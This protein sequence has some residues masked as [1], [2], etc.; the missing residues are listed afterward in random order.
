MS[1]KKKEGIEIIQRGR[2]DYYVPLKFET[3]CN[4]KELCG[5][6]NNSLNMNINKHLSELQSDMQDAY[7]MIQDN[8]YQNREGKILFKRAIKKWFR[9]QRDAQ[10]TSLTTS[11][12]DTTVDISPTESGIR[13][14]MHPGEMRAYTDRCEEL[15]RERTNYLRIYG[16]DLVNSQFRYTLLPLNIQLINGERVWLHAI[17]YVFENLMGI[18]KLE[19]PL[20]N[21]SSEPLKD[22][23][24]DAYIKS[25]D[26]HWNLIPKNCEL[27]IVN[28]W[29]AYIRKIEKE[30]KLKI[31]GQVGV[32]RN[33]ILAR[34]DNMPKQIHSI[35]GDVQED[36]YKIIAAP[37]PKLGCTSYRQVARD[38]IEKQSWNC[39][40]MRWL[41]S[42]TG[43]CLSFTDTAFLEWKAI[44]YL[45]N[46]EVDV[47]SN[48]D[49]DAIDKG[50]IQDLCFNTELALV[51]PILKFM[52]SSYTYSMK[53]YK[54]KEMH[55]VQ[56]KFNQNIMFI[57]RLQ[58]S[59][60][61]SVSEQI[62]V[63]ERLMP[64]YL[65]TKITSEKMH[66]L[67]CIIS[68]DERQRYDRLQSFLS[69]GGLIM[70]SV[71]G[72]PAIYETITIIRE[73]FAFI[74][75]DIPVLTIGNTSVGIWF[76]AMIVLVF[77]VYH[78]RRIK[79]KTR[80]FQ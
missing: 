75:Y 20:V 65:K 33:V 52:N 63:F 79:K 38:F 62:E 55:D 46:C 2:I 80:P 13:I 28:L 12:Y 51:I 34:F 43:G 22:N 16:E 39:Y 23:N 10:R 60:Y 71:F 56:T 42:P 72:L 31:L 77:R 64:Y 47:L 17:I 3:S 19:L 11:P 18:L 57:S 37:V 53:C 21:V 27:T 36:L 40:N 45:K 35:P 5:R 6:I 24:Y 78:P 41:L 8:E 32:I 67:D 50:M 14:T 15:H 76:L 49:M 25:I 68:D 30:T 48:D 1:Q 9:D 70:A 44:C 69:L 74:Q 59:C 58:E 73:F 7:D 26:D 29:N 54:P 4:F 61:G 66:A